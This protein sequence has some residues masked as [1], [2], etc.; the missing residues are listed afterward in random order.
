MAMGDLQSQTSLA[1][2]KQTGWQSMGTMFSNLSTSYG[3][4]FDTGVKETKQAPQN[5]PTY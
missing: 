3:N 5:Y 4:P 1:Q 2:A